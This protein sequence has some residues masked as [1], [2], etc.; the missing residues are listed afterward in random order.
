MRPFRFGVIVRNAASGAAWAE[1]ARKLEGLGYAVLAISDHLTQVLSPMPALAAAAT[2]TRTLRLGT[3]VLNNDLRHPVLVAREA[4]TLDFL[5]DGRLELGLGAGYARSE[6]EQAGLTFDRGRVR[7]ERL[8]EAIEIV[9]RLL[10]GDAVSFAGRHYRVTGHTVHPRPV[11]HPHPPILIG[12]NG[13]ELL[14]L[15][16]RAADVVGLTGIA[17]RSDGG[18]PDLSAWRAAAVDEQVRRVRETAGDRYERLEINALVQRV[19]VTDD[20]R[21]TAETLAREWPGLSAD[22]ILESPYTLL[23]TVDQ[24]VDDLRARRARWDI[25]YVLTHQPYVDALAPVVARLANE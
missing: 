21:A 4:A 25:S 16:A 22:E 2:A 15:A 13:P 10:A 20:R 19:I 18:A 7:V 1:Q 24:M 12:G 5:T 23:G 9:T 11:Q 6:Y 8:G 17:F 14:A 3:A